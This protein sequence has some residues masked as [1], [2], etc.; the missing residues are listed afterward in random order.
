M[1]RTATP[2]AFQPKR[3]LTLF[4]ST[5]IIVGIIIGSAIYESSP[6]IAAKSGGLAGLMGI[7]VLGGLLSLI[8]A[9][10]YAELANAY[11]RE[12]GD[13]VYVTKAF[14][15]R[16]GFL[17]GWAQLW[18]V[19]PGSI[20]AMAY[21]FAHYAN[22]LWPLARG[23][24]EYLAL[25]AYAAA[26]IAVLS[27]INLLGVREGKWTQNVLTTTKV[28]GLAAIAAVG[29]WFSTPTPEPAVSATTA[30]PDFGLAL[31]FVLFAYGGWSEMAYVSAEVRDPKRNILRALLLGTVAV[32]AIYLAVTLAFVHCLGLDGVRQANAV[33]ADVLNHG[34]GD[35]GGRAISL[36][37]CISALGAING[38]IFTGARIYY[39]MGND[40][41]LYAPLGR[42]SGRR[43]TP[44]CS[45]VVQAVITLATVSVFGL[46]VPSAVTE[47]GFT[48][49]VMFTTPVFWGFLCLVG[50]GLFVL[51][52]RQPQLERPYRVPLYPLIPT[53]F[54]CY[55]AFMV[56]QGV[57]YALDHRSYEGLWALAAIAIGAVMAFVNPKPSGTAE[58][59]PGEDR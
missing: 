42:W 44:V 17:F 47:S 5:S 55:T 3:Q 30:D 24:A 23:D 36:L 19:R 27:A 13:Y 53:V 4:D 2:D 11:P 12:G 10:C 43:D 54:C 50:V 14:G 57:V 6:L 59:A 28:L 21:I 49:M 52:V 48:K 26:S 38:Q 40:H 31:I 45:L 34:L 7:W 8:G 1:R 29:L 46:C 20:G 9:L 25:V 33:A 58:P 18:V 56:Y 51:R 32:A 22:Q 39:A 15:R 35:W 41:P 37:I 16:A